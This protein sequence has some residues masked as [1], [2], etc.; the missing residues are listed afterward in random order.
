MIVPKVK[1]VEVKILE[2]IVP[3][4]KVLKVN[5]LEAIQMA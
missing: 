5:V 1:V 2:V 4:V 3:K